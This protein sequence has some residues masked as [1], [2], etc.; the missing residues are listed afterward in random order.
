MH[1]YDL[2]K[3][4]GIL[5]VAL[6]DLFMG[7]MGVTN[8]DY[9]GF[10]AWTNLGYS[11]GTYSFHFWRPAWRILQQ[12]DAPDDV[13][14]ILREA[15]FV[16]GDRLGFGTGIER[17]N[18][19]AFSHIPIALKYCSEATQ[20]PMQLERYKVFFERWK[21]ETWG[22]GVGISRSGDSQE[23]FAHD[24]HYG[25]YVLA[26]LRAPLADFPGSEYQA[27]ALRVRRLYSYI[28]NPDGYANPWSSRT[29]HSLAKKEWAG[30]EMDW[31]GEPGKSFTV[32]PN[33][34]N[35]WFAARRKNYYAVTFHGRLA[36]MWLVNGFYG[37]IGFSGGI[38]CQLSVPGKG[39]LFHSR[40]KGG[41]G[42]G[43]DLPNWRNFELHSIVGTMADG[44]PF[45]SA[46]SEHMNARLN[47]NVVE[48][49]GEVR[50]RPVHVTR[51]FTFNDDDIVV[52]ANL[53][54][55][56]FTPL[57][58]LWSRDRAAKLAT[59]N[60]AWEM[61]PYPQGHLKKSDTPSKVM[62]SAADKKSLGELSESL[63]LGVST[64][65]VQRPGYGARIHFE[66]PITVKKG[67]QQTILIQLI[68]KPT[69]ADKVSIKYRIEPYGG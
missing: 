53:A 57:L 69:P 36:P 26:N 61:I 32:S 44:R 9:R 10:P 48:G 4:K 15:L 8:G 2:H 67:G 18:G 5:N 47:G 29:M 1:S 38:L 25:S 23:H 52:E 41:Y 56:G 20:D 58:T 14:A 21:S 35:E 46:V 62:L 59:M 7:F 34:G 30:E 68:D 50:D 12:S 22:I 13:K 45:V 17:V 55:S 64:I 49:S 66:N 33:D 60:E 24:N 63:T 11:F 54:T 28:W 42:K 6:R 3:Q 27:V 43:M 40:L 37:Q 19:N 16:G 31:M 39:L 65:D 51:R